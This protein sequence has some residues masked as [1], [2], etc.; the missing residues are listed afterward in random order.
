MG[1]ECTLQ[2]ICDE[3]KTVIIHAFKLVEGLRWR[4]TQLKVGEAGH[5]LFGVK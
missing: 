5:I 3:T 4:R 1:V 2:I